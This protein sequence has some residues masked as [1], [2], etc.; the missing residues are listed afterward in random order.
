MWESRM[1]LGQTRPIPRRRAPARS[2]GKI[3]PISSRLSRAHPRPSEPTRIDRSPLTFDFFSVLQFA[4]KSTWF[5]NYFLLPFINAL[6]SV[7]FYSQTLEV[8][9]ISVAELTI[10]LQCSFGSEL[11][12]LIFIAN[13]RRIL[14]LIELRYVSTVS[15][16]LTYVRG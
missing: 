5:C 16:V 1:F 15:I 6:L 14:F 8:T 9:I 3:W 13:R 10:L 11:I 12:Q 4:V 7:F 2:A